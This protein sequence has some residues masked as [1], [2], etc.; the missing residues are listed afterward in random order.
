MRRLLVLGGIAAFV[1]RAA[2][3]GAA[4]SS[5]TEL[6]QDFPTSGG[7]VSEWKL[8]YDIQRMPD[9]SGSP[10]ASETLILSEA[11]FRPGAAATP[12][13]V[14]G[15][16][17]LVEIFVPYNSGGP[18]F[19]D[20]TGFD[21]DLQ[22]LTTTECPSTRLSG[23]RICKEVSDRDLAW[24]DPDVPIAR[25]GERLVL[26]SLLNAA[27]YDYVMYYAFY[28]DGTIEVRAGSTGRK[29]GGPDDT[30]GHEHVF[31]W[32]INLDVAGAGG[33]TV[34]VSNQSFGG[35]SVREKAEVLS[36]EAGVPWSA[37]GFTDVEVDD[38]ARTNANGRLTGYA[39]KPLRSGLPKF[40]EPWTRYPIWVT[41]NHP[42]E[43][44]AEG[45]PGYLDR[46]S[47]ENQDV[48]LWY[49][50]THHHEQNMR[51]EDRDTV[52]VLWTTFQLVPQNLWNGTP[53]YP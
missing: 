38:N 41:R 10:T 27:N 52:P 47:V 23:N 1:L 2:A 34:S 22:A 3:A 26:W 39:L 20:L 51:D 40:R 53:F 13:S 8:C 45:L 12:V 48:V 24:R 19:T 4:C 43:L 46:E 36:T 33:D 32:R 28:D 29:L 16:L 25:R 31:A 14:L 5:G 44:R 7:A 42:N 35:K 6:I 9:E 11:T 30:E 17:R 15:D 18:R 21:F 49:L 37:A 50:D